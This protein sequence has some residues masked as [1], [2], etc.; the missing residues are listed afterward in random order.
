[1]QKAVPEMSAA[2]AI[3]VILSGAVSTLVALAGLV[4]W[5]YQRGVAAG[6]DRAGHTA[7]LAR[8]CALEQEL[9]Q[10]RAELVEFMR[11]RRRG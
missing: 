10:T 2:E 9:A 3:A 11:K 7:D 8:I 6:I 1:M 4:W 5:A